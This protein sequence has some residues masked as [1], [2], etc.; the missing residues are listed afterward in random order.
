[1][2]PQCLRKRLTLQRLEAGEALQEAGLRGEQLLGGV[3]FRHRQEAGR[4][5]LLGVKPRLR[6]S[7]GSRQQCLTG[8]SRIVAGIIG[9][10]RKILVKKDVGEQADNFRLVRDVLQIEA[11]GHP[12]LARRFVEP[13][14]Q[15][16]G[17][18][19]CES[20]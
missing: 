19:R 16:G 4:Q 17:P 8:A 18:H 5:G 14:A 9:L 20:G 3:V 13:T 7:G 2:D 1:M 11:L 10:L 15:A 12:A 6:R